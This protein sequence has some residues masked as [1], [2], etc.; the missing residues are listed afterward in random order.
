MSADSVI[1][2]PGGIRNRMTKTYKHPPGYRFRAFAAGEKKG[3][4]AGRYVAAPNWVDIFENI[5]G[6]GAKIQE[7]APGTRSI[8][9][10]GDMPVPTNAGQF[11]LYCEGNLTRPAAAGSIKLAPGKKIYLEGCVT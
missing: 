8:G 1:K 4:P 6:A 3:L 9:V 11:P 2:L 5:A 10:K 7:V